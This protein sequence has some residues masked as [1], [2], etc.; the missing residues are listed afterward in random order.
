MLD[1]MVTI[2]Y[3]YDSIHEVIFMAHN[4]LKLSPLVGDDMID[5]SGSDERYGLCHV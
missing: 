2:T 1:N 3:E 4:D 5:N